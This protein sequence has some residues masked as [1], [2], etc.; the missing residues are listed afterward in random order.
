MDHCLKQRLAA[1]CWQK[2]YE[3][4]PAILASSWQPA[5]NPIFLD[6]LYFYLIIF[7]RARNWDTCSLPVKQMLL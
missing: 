1:G 2:G 5:A 4:V 6:T 7:D 3:Q